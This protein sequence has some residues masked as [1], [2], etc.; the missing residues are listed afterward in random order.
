MVIL[1]A[2]NLA[3]LRVLAFWEVFPGSTY[4][5][6]NI[7]CISVDS[8]MKLV[9]VHHIVCVKFVHISFNYTDR[10]SREP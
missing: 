1:N 2:R 5:S 7:S 6:E 10:G 9:R 8:G 3:L 4:A